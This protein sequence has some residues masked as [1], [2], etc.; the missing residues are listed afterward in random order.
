MSGTLP[1]AEGWALAHPAVMKRAAAAFTIEHLVPANGPI[2]G[3]GYAATGHNE[4]ELA[5]NRWPHDRH[6][7]RRDQATR[8]AAPCGR[9]GSPD[10][11]RVF[12]N[13]GIPHVA[14]FGPNYLL[15]IA[16]NGHMDKLDA[17]LPRARP[18]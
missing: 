12:H 9:G 1:E 18:R 6:G 15:S 5:R 2:P 11:G 17:D 7:R 4:Y 10:T 13:S 8:S 16:A 3:K 14:C